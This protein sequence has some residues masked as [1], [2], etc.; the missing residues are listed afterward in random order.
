VVQQRA[1][2]SA[3]PCLVIGEVASL[4]ADGD[5]DLACALAALAR[6]LGLRTA[7]L[8]TGGA[9]VGDAPEPGAP[10][11]EVPVYGGS[12]ALAGTLTVSGGSAADLPALRSVAAVLGLALAPRAVDDSEQALDDLA[13]ALHDGPVQS[14]VVAR[15]ASDAA[16][17]GGDPA[18][19]RDAVQAALIE[20]RRFLWRV[21][22]RGSAG[23]VEALDQLSTHLV[24]AGG[25]PLA[26]LGDVEAAAALRG[27]M[28][29]LAYRLVQTLAEGVSAT[30][31]VALRADAESLTVDVAASLDDDQRDRWN[32]RAQGLGGTLTT[33]ASRTRLVLPRPPDVR[34]LP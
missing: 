3:D 18:A 11:F 31:R 2:D 29:V 33:S 15:Y 28:G 12:G 9:L 19:A 26:V 20:A 10:V 4:L 5:S 24:E 21:R 32:R 14:L 16:A 13:D 30:L 25:H 6:G 1:A 17:R 34:T 7:A 22:P 27:P 8:R 23:L